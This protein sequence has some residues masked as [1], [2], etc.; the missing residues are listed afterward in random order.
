MRSTNV[1]TLP[2]SLTLIWEMSDFTVYQF[3]CP[4]T[5]PRRES[6]GPL[7]SCQRNLA[8]QI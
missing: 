3:E 1:H 8:M 6:T 7:S 2:T 4:S 5:L